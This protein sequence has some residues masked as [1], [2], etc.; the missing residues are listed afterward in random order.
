MPARQ[1]FIADDY[2][3]AN[4]LMEVAD[5]DKPEVSAGSRVLDVRNQTKYLARHITGAV[6]VDLS[7]W[8]KAFAAG[9]DSSIWEEKI[10]ALGIALDTPVIIYDDG[11]G[12]DAAHLRLILRYWGVKDVRLVNGGWCS[13]LFEGRKQDDV[14]P[15]ITARP[16]T[17]WAAPA[18][19]AQM[20]QVLEVAQTGREQIIDARSSAEFRGETETARRNGAIPTAKNVPWST[21]FDSQ[22]WRFKSPKQLAEQFRAAGIDPTRPTITYCRSGDRAAAMAFTL[23]LMG[24]KRVRVYYPGWAEWGNAA[25]TPL[26]LEPKMK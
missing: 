5:V 17:L 1:Y 3:R 25:D 20:D 10:G 26:A 15:K 6:W 21:I 19:L 23:E 12:N 22:T 7:A 14:E 4:L 9:Q 11:P 24:A 8:A 18:R 2:P 13:W 16:I